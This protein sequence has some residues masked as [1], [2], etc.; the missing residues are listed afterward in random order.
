M[1]KTRGRST[2]GPKRP[3]EVSVDTDTA[4]FSEHDVY[5]FNEGTHYRLYRHLGAHMTERDGQAGVAFGVWA[6]NAE[7]VSVVGDFNGWQPRQ[8]P[9]DAVGGSGVWTGF[10]PGLERGTI[11]KYHVESR[12]NGYRVNKADPFGFH[13]ETPPATGS[14]VW[15]LDYE[16][17]DADWMKSRAGRQRLDSPISIYEVHA[18]SWMMSPE[19]GGRTHSFEE[20]AELLPKYCADRGFT[21]VEFLPIMEHPLYRSWGYQTTGYFAP[22]SRFGTPQ[23]FMNLVDRL[24]Q[25]NIGVILDW[26]PSHFPSDEHGLGYFDGTHLFEH[27]DPRQG[28][29]PDWKSLIFN[30]GRNEVRAF[31]ISSAMFWLD[32]YHIDGLR[33]DAVAS[34]LYLD[35][36]RG[37]G[38]WIPNRHGGNANLEAID[39]LQRLNTEV[40]R[41]FP[42]VQT[43]AEESTSW[44]N[45]SKPVYDGGLGFGFKW[46]MGWMHDTLQHFSRDAAHRRY[47]YNELT[48]RGMYM[49]S[50]HFTLPLS[51]DE[52][53]HGKGSLF[54][55]MAGDEWQKLANLRLLLANQ[56][57]QPGKKLLFMGGEIG[58]RIEWDEERELDW[59]ILQNH[60]H[61]GVQRLVDRLNAI[62][63]TVPAMHELDASPEGFRWLQADDADHGVLAFLRI[64]R[65]RA[66]PVICV[67]NTTPVARHD[68]LVGAPSPG[69][70]REILNTDASEYG[71][72][73][74]GNMGGRESRP[75]AHQGEPHALRLTLP[76]LGAL[77]L[78][79]ARSHDSDDAASANA[80]DPA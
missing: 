71:G 24:H 52:V 55:K 63:T 34:M 75:I 39:F 53:V 62:Y 6:P 30:Y 56:W 38:E 17:K 25:A 46:D 54:T 4:G 19:H 61:A 70:W 1:P 27:A 60:G 67:F 77:M 35:Y 29:H 74:V 5:L 15:D 78:R 43:Y 66:D 80:K 49:H 32:K 72:S 40:Y 51:H 44:P 7:R 16:W 68:I 45:V 21:H 14:R 48:F 12:H 20:L 59:P 13:H 47:H 9:L 36:S 18:G 79:L 58:Q 65:H 69:Y 26:V 10:I 28:F 33:V 11:Y 37:A 31:L 3:V 2:T 64:D 76:P 57:M 22:T 8:H 41:S 73:G 50:E 23:G 42:D